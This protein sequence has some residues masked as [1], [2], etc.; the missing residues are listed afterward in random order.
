MLK[1]VSIIMGVREGR[2]AFQ[3][4]IEENMTRIFNQLCEEDL[5]R[6]SLYY[7][8]IDLVNETDYDPKDYQGIVTFSL[9]VIWSRTA[10]A[11]GEIVYE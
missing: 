2:M 9:T 7:E 6:V 4:N 8:T 1:H 5:C 11:S 3:E 10:D